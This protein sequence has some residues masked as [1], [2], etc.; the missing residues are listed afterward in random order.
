MAQIKIDYKTGY[1]NNKFE[2]VIPPVYEFVRDFY[3][4][5]AYVKFEDKEGYINKKGQWVW[6]KEREGM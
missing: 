3:G 6:T 5:L 4:D 1:I 2:T